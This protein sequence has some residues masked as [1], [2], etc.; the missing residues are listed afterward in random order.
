MFSLELSY[1]VLLALS[2]AIVLGMS[3][4]I[5]SC[6]AT[7]RKQ[8]LLGDAISHAALPGICL[9]FMLT[10]NKHP[11]F[12]LL[13]A[14]VSGFL[15]T[16]FLLILIRNTPI[17]SD[18]ALGIILSVFFGVGILLLTM[19]QKIPTARQSGLEGYLF[20]NA[21]SLL[22]QD[23]YIM[24]VCLSLIIFT[25][26]LLWKE[27][28]CLVFD[29]VYFMALGYPGTR[30]EILLT[31]LLVLTIVIGLQSVGVILMSALI[32]APGTAARQWTD[33]LS[34]MVILSVL[35]AVTAGIAGVLL[36]SIIPRW[37]TGP[38]IVLMIS[39]IVLFS[40]L[41]APNRGLLFQ[42][43]QQYRHRKQ[44]RNDTILQ[45]LFELAK[46]HSDPRHPHHIN[47]LELIGGKPTRSAL[48]QLEEKG[49]VR[50]VESNTWGL[51]DAGLEIARGRQSEEYGS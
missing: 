28:K 21:A 37:P 39:A 23:V 49:W 50:E 34:V 47:T 24:L 46:S 8:S 40:L 19:I 20:G 48:S 45:Q 33:R 3:S 43:I 22:I 38:S 30:M 41:F 7:L 42:W 18:T 11:V 29:R 17:K 9:A 35:F 2:G 6:Y 1:P 36:S 25:V 51:T 5:L 32:I 14:L 16:L 10:L 15:G 12:L 27:F 26:V 31:T 44:L 13:G 4:G